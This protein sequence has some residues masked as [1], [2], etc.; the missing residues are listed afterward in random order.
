M[1]TYVYHKFLTTMLYYRAIVATEYVNVGWCQSADATTLRQGR[2]G[3][4]TNKSHPAAI[5]AHTN[6]GGRAGKEARW[7]WPTTPT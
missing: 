4:P 2:R 7:L 5:T 6:K 3:M 1:Y